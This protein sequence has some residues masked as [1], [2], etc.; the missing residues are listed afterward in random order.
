MRFTCRFAPSPNGAL[1]LGHALSAFINHDA[2]AAAGGTF[3]LRIEDIDA[4]RSRPAFEQAIREDL[5]WLGILPAAPPRRQSEHF[6][7]YA[8]ALARLERAGLLYPAF[9]SRAEIARA[10]ALKD[11][12]GPWPRDPDGAPLSPFARSALP[13]RERARL[14]AAGA[15]FLLR[16]D[17]AAALARIGVPLD[18]REAQGTPL[19]PRAIQPAEPAA[20]GDVVIARKD[21]PASYH[22]AVVMDDAIQEISHVIR[23]RDLFAATAVHRVLQQLLG[24]PAP[25]YHHHRLVLGADGRKLSKSEGAASL[26]ALRQAGAGPDEI[27]RQLGLPPQPTPRM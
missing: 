18:W 27:R 26:A 6:A 7:L 3:L 20:W 15:P 5:D 1:H 12:E 21:V 11:R 13:D 14:R 19:G 8:E 4:T 2:A 17:M 10:V 24:L 9:E 22:L 25:V 23:G 16:L